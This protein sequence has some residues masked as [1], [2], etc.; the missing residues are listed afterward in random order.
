MVPTIGVEAG[1]CICIVTAGPGPSASR[2]GGDRSQSD[3]PELNLASR[4]HVDSGLSASP[5]HRHPA[6]PRGSLLFKD[7]KGVDLASVRV[8]ARRD[9]GQR[10]A[11]TRHH[12]KS[13]LDDLPGTHAG[14]FHDV[15]INA[16]VGG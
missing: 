8:C 12:M 15:G 13:S 6:A 2:A 4:R 5:F 16:S 7:R 14:E 3:G 11:I 1:T 10:L 9:Y